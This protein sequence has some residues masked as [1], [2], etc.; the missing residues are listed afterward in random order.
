[1]KIHENKLKKANKADV[2][3]LARFMKINSHEYSY[4]ELIKVI[5]FQ[6]N[7]FSVNHRGTGYY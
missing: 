3:R 2:M 4:H 1:M 7:T 5:T 6:C